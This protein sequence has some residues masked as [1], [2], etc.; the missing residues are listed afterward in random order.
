MT[1]D[2]TDTSL[3]PTDLDL[4]EALADL[5]AVLDLTRVG[6]TR[7]KV[8]MHE[9]GDALA[10]IGAEVFIARSLRTSHHRVFGGQVLAQSIMAAGQ[11]V[12]SIHPDRPIHS[13]HAYFLRTGDDSQPIRFAVEHLRDGHSFSAR[14][15][16]ALQDGE[17]ILTMTASFQDPAPG[18]EHQRPMPVVPRPEELDSLG[19]YY[20]G[21]DLPGTKQIIPRPIEHRHV[22]GNLYNAQA[23]HRSYKQSVW[24]RAVGALPDDPLLHAAV[25]AFA[26]DYTILETIIREHQLVWSEP[27]LRAASLDHSMWFHRPVKFDDWVLYDQHSP[28][29]QGGRGLGIGHIYSPDGLLLASV[30]QEGMLR[31]KESLRAEAE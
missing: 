9:G 26:S 27:R 2:N 28:S 13:L 21:M 30:A 3:E 24:L 29:A 15:V 10:D 20:T 5:L 17:T 6:E 14:R 23:T 18:I 7:S 25:L 8:A 4:Q 16:Y 12:R 1:G 11:T 22:Q 19:E 31:I